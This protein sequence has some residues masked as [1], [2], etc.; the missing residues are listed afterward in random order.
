[1]LSVSLSKMSLTCLYFA[2]RILRQSF[3]R[4]C[5]NLV[6]QSRVVPRTWWTTTAAARSRHACL[7]LF[8]FDDRSA[9]R[10]AVGIH[11]PACVAVMFKLGIAR[12]G[13]PSLAAKSQCRADAGGTW[14]QSQDSGYCSRQILREFLRW[15][16]LSTTRERGPCRSK[17]HGM[18]V[19]IVFLPPH[20]D[21]LNDSPLPSPV[22]SKRERK[23]KKGRRIRIGTV[24]TQSHRSGRVQSP[25]DRKALG[26]RG[27]CQSGFA[28]LTVGG[29]CALVECWQCSH[30]L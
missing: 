10:A 30:A 16:R 5:H 18:P 3:G 27:G 6:H 13:T 24:A 11:A 14:Y 26:R 21:Q 2:M 25:P 22:S 28:N 17:C 4:V 7:G 19:G 23:R 12:D 9:Q 29:L 8:G 1:M 15:R 20:P